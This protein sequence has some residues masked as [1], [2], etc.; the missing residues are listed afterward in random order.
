[1]DKFIQSNTK[2]SVK[3]R[4]ML[5]LVRREGGTKEAAQKIWHDI[6]KGDNWINDTYHVYVVKDDPHGFGDVEVWWLS[7]KRHDRELIMDWREFQEI[8]NAICGEQY[9]GIMLYP[10]EDRVVD[11]SNQFHL[12]VFMEEDYVIP[13]GFTAGS[14]TDDPNFGKAKQRSRT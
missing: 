3:W 2:H 8:K 1:M 4:E 11:T 13:C 14:K 6:N 7:I 9:E 10:R 12:F 5:A